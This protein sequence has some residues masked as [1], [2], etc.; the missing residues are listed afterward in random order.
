MGAVE[1]RLLTGQQFLITTL[2]FKI[3]IM[4]LLTVDLVATG[5]PTGLWLSLVGAFLIVGATGEASQATVR[6]VLRGRTGRRNSGRRDRQNQRQ[7]ARRCCP[8]GPGR[9][10]ATPRRSRRRRPHGQVIRRERQ[11]V[12]RHPGG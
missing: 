1:T 6:R 8:R 7:P 3:A 5:V 9:T 11:A 12:A 4:A 10:A 2:V